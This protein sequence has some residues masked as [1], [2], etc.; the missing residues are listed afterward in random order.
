LRATDDWFRRF[1]D[2][3][4]TKVSLRGVAAQ[5]HFPVVNG[6]SFTTL[7]SDCLTIDELGPG[8]D[9]ACARPICARTA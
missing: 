6:S 2:R 5:V 3:H 9:P 1:N 4:G 8:S 7:F